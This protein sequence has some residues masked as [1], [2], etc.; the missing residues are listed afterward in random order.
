VPPSPCTKA[1]AGVSHVRVF[2]VHAAITTGVRVLRYKGGCKGP[3]IFGRV[4]KATQ[5]VKTSRICLISRSFPSCLFV[6]ICCQAPI[7]HIRPP[8][9]PYCITQS[10]I[11]EL[12]SENLKHV[13]ATTTARRLRRGNP[14][15]SH[16]C[17]CRHN[18]AVRDTTN[19]LPRYRVNIWTSRVRN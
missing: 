14:A 12:Y 6:L 8:V 10:N 3:L 4:T 9:T 15:L 5:L 17:E 13:R 11:V 18:A 1:T 2:L 7:H 19:P 16:T